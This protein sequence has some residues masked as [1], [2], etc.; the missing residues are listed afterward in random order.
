M[1]S[2]PSPSI[3]EIEFFQPGWGCEKEHERG[4][5]RLTRA[6]MNCFL[7]FWW[8]GI[9]GRLGLARGEPDGVEY[10]AEV[11]PVA[12]HGAFNGGF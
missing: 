9:F 3:R 8:M 6:F 10:R 12:A 4:R 2:C 1:K 5:S 11:A 7:I